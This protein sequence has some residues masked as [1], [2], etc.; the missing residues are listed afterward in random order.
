M[1]TLAIC[2]TAFLGFVL[3]TTGTSAQGLFP[4][5]G[6]ATTTAVIKQADAE[7]LDELTRDVE[8]LH[9][10]AML[11][12]A[13]RLEEAGRHDDALFWYSEGQIR[14]L[15]YIMQ[16]KD[17]SEQLAWERVSSG[18]GAQV[19]RHPA[20]DAERMRNA[21]DKALAWDLNHPDDFTPPGPAK[22]FARKMLQDLKANVVAD[23]N[24]LAREKKEAEQEASAS[25]DD[26]YPGDGGAMFGTPKELVPPYD[27]SKFSG[28]KIGVTSKSEVARA[29]GKP[30]LWFTNA[31][32]SSALSYPVLMTN[33]PMAKFGLVRRAEV[34]FKFDVKLIL[35]EIDLPK[36]AAP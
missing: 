31:D 7:P 33:D 30:E 25:P 19:N 23:P 27:P 28:F 16:S 10:G 9:P 35:T 29:L 3:T 4:P 14:W 17:R 5:S 34:T 2:C 21:I 13:K 22:D 8:R 18:I 11:I 15:G 36:N 26:P 1:R 32:G 6:N 12:L 20:L 24:E